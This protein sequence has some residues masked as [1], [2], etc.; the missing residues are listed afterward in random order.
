MRRRFR[1]RDSLKPFQRFVQTEAAGGVLLL[2]C[3]G[4]AIALVN[5][6]WADAYEHL[7]TPPIEIRIAN[8][9]INLTVRQWINDGLMAVFFLMVG[10]EI[11]REMLAGELA[12]PQQAALPIAGAIGGML[13][14][15]ALYL[16]VNP[17]GLPARGWGVPMAT[18]IA[19]ALGTLSLA[20]P[21]N[22]IEL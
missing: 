12:A 13:V 15:A 19:F 10:L 16:I 18:D 20:A 8:R 2:V 17:G 22:G 5:S 9:V 21:K 3:A 11:K 14:P 4:V 1:L 6:P 7:W